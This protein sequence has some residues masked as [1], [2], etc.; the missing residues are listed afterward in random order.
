M[1]NLSDVGAR[2][3]QAYSTRQQAALEE[4]IVLSQ[5]EEAAG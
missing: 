2:R 5:K 4:A 1:L 3:H